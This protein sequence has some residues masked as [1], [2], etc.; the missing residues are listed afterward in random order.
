MA[1]REQVNFDLET[2]MIDRIN[3]ENPHLAINNTDLNYIND[4]D[5]IQG[6]NN[7]SSFNNYL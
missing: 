7:L 2:C 6:L 3:K 1:E 4:Y 5:S